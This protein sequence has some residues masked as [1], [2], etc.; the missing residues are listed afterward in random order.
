MSKI[1]VNIIKV[2]EEHLLDDYGKTARKISAEIIIVGGHNLKSS[3]TGYLF[4]DEELDRMSSLVKAVIY[5]IQ[6]RISSLGENTEGQ[7]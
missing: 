1:E 3:N 6:D 7:K 5:E 2:N 4:Q